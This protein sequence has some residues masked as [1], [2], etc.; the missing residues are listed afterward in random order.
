MKNKILSIGLSICLFMATA[1][2]IDWPP[3]PSG[4]QQGGRFGAYMAALQALLFTDSGKVGIGVTPTGGAI[5][6]VNGNI[7]AADPTVNTHVAT[8][9]YVD[10]AVGA[11]GDAT[12]ANQTILIN[13]LGSATYGL[14]A[15]KTA[16][17][18]ISGGGGGG[19]EIIAGTYFSN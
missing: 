12:V 19:G 4:E 16:V 14:N 2:A 11:A 7:S 1:L 5:L 9:S 10:G 15:I 18:E 17:N 13:Q 6:E 3:P 8:K